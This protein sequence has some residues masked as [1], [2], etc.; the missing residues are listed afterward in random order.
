M[1][2]FVVLLMALGLGSTTFARVQGD[3]TIG[4]KKIVKSVKNL[5]K[6]GS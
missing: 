6:D 5:L 3:V 1:K 4:S 2:K